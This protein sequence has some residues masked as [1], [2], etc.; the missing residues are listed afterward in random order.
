MLFPNL[1]HTNKK[2][3]KKSGFP[4]GFSNK[5][6]NYNSRS[7][8]KA[9]E[10]EEMKKSW[11][12]KRQ[13]F[14]YFGII[15]NFVNYFEYSAVSITALY[16]YKETFKLQN[17]NFYYGFGFSCMCLS[18]LLSVFICGF[19]MDRT[20]DLRKIVPTA[21]LFCA[22][23]NLMY[24]M[25]FSKWLPVIGRLLCGTFDGITISIAGDLNTYIDT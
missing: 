22:F 10:K 12:R 14:T 3:R 6:E 9:E 13:I 21:T 25:T 19:L 11:Y 2:T 16:Y 8:A 17:P 5:K 23:G 18:S 4:K 7:M 1:Q 24:T 20:R 15:V